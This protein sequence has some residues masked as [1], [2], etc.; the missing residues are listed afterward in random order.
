VT[1]TPGSDTIVPSAR[2]RKENKEK[3]E[4]RELKLENRRREKKKSAL[5]LCINGALGRLGFSRRRRKGF[6]FETRLTLRTGTVGYT[7]AAG[8]NAEMRIRAWR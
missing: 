2:R 5:V 8:R 7:L 4:I 6:G 3:I 1:P